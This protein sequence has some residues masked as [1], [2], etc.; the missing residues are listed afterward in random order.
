VDAQA[1]HVD[2]TRRIGKF[3]QSSEAGFGRSQDF[4][5]SGTGFTR[6]VSAAEQFRP[7]IPAWP[8]TADNLRR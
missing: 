1:I 3:G 8:L 2:V 4:H 7:K 6:A 5:R